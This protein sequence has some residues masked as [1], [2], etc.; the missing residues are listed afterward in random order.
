MKKDKRINVGVM[1][2]KEY[3]LY[4]IAFFI[5]CN[6]Y[7]SISYSYLNMNESRGFY[8]YGALFGNVIFTSM[9]FCFISAFARKM[10]FSRPTQKI[11]EAARKIAEGDLSVRV[12]HIRKDGKVDDIEVMIEDFNKMAEELASIEIMKNDFI[13][14]VSHEIKTPLSV[15]QNYAMAI[16]EEELTTD[17]RREYARTIV[18]ASQR[19]SDLITNI[20]R[21]NKLENQEIFEKPQTFQVSEQIRC[22]LLSF[23]EVWERKSIL[24]ESQI[25][26]VDICSHEQL[27][28]IVWNNLISNA[29][30]YTNQQ[31]KI[32]ITLKKDRSRVIFILEDNGCGMNEVTLKH[33]FEK[34]YQGDTSHSLEGNGL[35]MA[36][37]KRIIDIVQGEIKVASEIGKGCKVTVIL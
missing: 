34:F 21:L 20:L 9:F 31:G 18:S 25:E 24:V 11:A 30:K 2:F 7:N 27:L 15:I 33:I 22:C 14:N 3:A 1:S 19:M 4:F 16:F 6:A 8:F 32:T 29:L 28:E 37:V 12:E 35:G 26:E 36:L 13:S 5:I 23:E 10:Y 17:E